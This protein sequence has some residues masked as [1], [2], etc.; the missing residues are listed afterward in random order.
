MANLFQKEKNM[1]NNAN[2]LPGS[3]AGQFEMAVNWGNILDTKATPWGIPTAQADA[4]EALIIAAQAALNATQG[5]GRG[6]VATQ[7]CKTAFA[8]LVEKMRFIKE[9]YFFVP[10][11]TDTDVISLGLKL[12]DTTNTPTPTPG[13]Q[14]TA[15]HRPLRDHLLELVMNIIGDLESDATSSDYGYRVY[16]GIM[17][18]G[19]AA[20]E[21]A[22]GTK[23][24]LMTVPAGGEELPFS[25]FTRKKKEV[26]DFLESDRGK[27]VYFCIRLENA[28]GHPGPW[29]PLFS[30]VIP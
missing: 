2:W 7:N 16:W 30:T 6:P 27:T 17:P 3:R 21:T 19:G 15:E 14:A 4:L 11:L 5:A 1:A 9:R 26:F 20:V 25:R 10:P 18:A 29:G 8:D 24:E 28:K 22:T 23:R 13:N 12:K